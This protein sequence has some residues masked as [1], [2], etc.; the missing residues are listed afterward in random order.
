MYV[1]LYARM[2]VCARACTRVPT[3]VCVYVDVDVDDDDDVHDGDGDGD[4]NV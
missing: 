2:S 4:D 1:W 3:Y